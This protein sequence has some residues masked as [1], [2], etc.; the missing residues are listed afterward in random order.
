M[1]VP[2]TYN[3]A[4]QADRPTDALYQHV[5]DLL[6]SWYSRDQAIQDLEELYV[7]LQIEGSDVQQEAVA[8]LLDALAGWFS[9]CA[10]L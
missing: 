7:H 6:E 5:R 1:T 8:D 2:A 10:T 4:L 9:P 3:D